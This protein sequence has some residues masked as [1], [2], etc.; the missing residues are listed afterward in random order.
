MKVDKTCI[1]LIVDVIG[2]ANRRLYEMVVSYLPMNIK[3]CYLIK[4]Y[5][6]LAE[7]S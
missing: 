6:A 3:P 5:Y 2:I 4:T 7:L 1:L